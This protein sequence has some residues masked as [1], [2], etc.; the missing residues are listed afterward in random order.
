[1][2]AHLVGPGAERGRRQ[3]SRDQE[4]SGTGCDLLGRQFQAQQRAG[5]PDAQVRVVLQHQQLRSP[6][7]ICH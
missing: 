4:G 5:V 2:A 7:A 3:D 6:G 1:V